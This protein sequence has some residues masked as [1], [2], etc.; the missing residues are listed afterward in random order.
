MGSLLADPGL[1][2]EPD[3]DRPAE[4]TGGQGILQQAGEVFLKASSA[5]AIFRGWHGRGC[6]RVSPSWRS[7]RP[8]VFS[9]TSTENRRDTSACKSTQRQR[10]TLCSARSEPATTSALSPPSGPCS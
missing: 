3:L 10:T 1:V 2:L 9:C 7:H 6:S 8:I 4:S 5:S